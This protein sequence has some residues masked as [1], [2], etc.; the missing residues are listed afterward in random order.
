MVNIVFFS[1]MIVGFSYLGYK[2][3]F[4]LQQVDDLVFAK[5]G[6]KIRNAVLL[7]DFTFAVRIVYHISKISI[8]DFNDDFLYSVDNDTW[9]APMI[10]ICFIVFAE[11]I[12]I[13]A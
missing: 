1:L 7:L 2:I 12:P 5:Y 4:V 8:A 9:F 11:L 6:M 10:F 13:A 3:Y